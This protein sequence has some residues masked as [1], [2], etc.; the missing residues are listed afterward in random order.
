MAHSYDRKA[1]K[2]AVNLSV[3]RDLVNAARQAG[4]NLSAVLEEALAE[5][6]A[7]A[8]REHWVRENSDAIAE[9]NGF[10]EEHGMMSDGTR[11]F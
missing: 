4:V 10:V 6:L 11:R 1:L 8:R 3:N 5:K 9:Y 7:A 2:Q